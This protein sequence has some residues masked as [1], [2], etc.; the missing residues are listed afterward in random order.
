MVLPKGAD[1]ALVERLSREIETIASKPQTAKRFGQQGI[2]VEHSTPA[3]F[4]QV[5]ADDKARWG[6]VIRT[7]QVHIE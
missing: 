6:E 2:S 4:A 7:A 1:P 5:I 3:S